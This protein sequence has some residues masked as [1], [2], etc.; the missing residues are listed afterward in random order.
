MPRFLSW[1]N[2]DKEMIKWFIVQV[3]VFG[4][5]KI[6]QRGVIAGTDAYEYSTK[7]EL[8]TINV[9]VRKAEKTEYSAYGKLCA[10]IMCA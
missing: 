10:N 1:S 4:S 9:N 7:A 8:V 2:I 3:Y 5:F 6:N